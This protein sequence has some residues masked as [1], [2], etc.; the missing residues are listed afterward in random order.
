MHA[1]TGNVMA[2]TVDGGVI[3]GRVATGES[4]PPG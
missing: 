2:V 3:E 4:F 1:E